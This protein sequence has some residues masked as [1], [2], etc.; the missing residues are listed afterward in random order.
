MPVI[1]PCYLSRACNAASHTIDAI[2]AAI[3]VPHSDEDP[4]DRLGLTGKAC[5]ARG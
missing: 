4:T 1:F 5:R 3:T 2:W